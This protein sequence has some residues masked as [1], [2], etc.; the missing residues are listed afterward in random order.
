[1]AVDASRYLDD[2]EV[3]ALLDKAENRALKDL[4]RGRMTG[5][6]AW[7]VVATAINT[8]LR[9]S[10][11]AALQVQDLDL[12][13]GS[14]YVE[15]RKRRRKSKPGTKRLMV[16]NVSA[17][18][19]RETLAIDPQFAERLKDYLEARAVRIASMEPEQAEGLTE[20]TGPLFVGQR[21][22]LGVQGLQQVWSTAAENAKVMRTNSKGKRVPKSIHTARHTMGVKLLKRTGNLYQ[23]QRQ[24]GHASPATTANFYCDIAFEDMQKGVTGLFDR[25]KDAKKAKK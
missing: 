3:E 6:L 2:R 1:M 19:V 25:K 11:L 5:V 9:V 10:E 13:K 23:V 24:L 14:L 15:R 18:P 7:A 17:K 16:Q 21:G 8:G 22:P 12:R 20:T 4:R